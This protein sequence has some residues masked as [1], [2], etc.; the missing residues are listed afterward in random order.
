MEHC[1]HELH[2]SHGHVSIP[3][4]DYAH[5]ME[6]HAMCD[7]EYKVHEQLLLVLG[8]RCVVNCDCAM[9]GDIVESST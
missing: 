5:G 3:S 4:F 1:V 6:G 9:C 7:V 8:I 2:V